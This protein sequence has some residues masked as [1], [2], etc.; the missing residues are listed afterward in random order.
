MSSSLNVYAL[1]MERLRQLIGSRDQTTIDAIV[2]GKEDFF[3]GVDDIHEEVE[4]T[5]ADAVAELLNG[6]W[7]EDAPGYLYGYALEAICSHIGETLPNICPISRASDWI[8]E[9]DALLEDKGIPV[10][11][12]GLVDGGS[13]VPIPEPD[14]Y[15]FIGTWTAAELALAKSAF[16]SADLTDI[17][18]EMALT[19]QQVRDWVQAAERNPGASLIG[20]LS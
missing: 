14:D 13:P 18:P 19:L 17:D 20:F 8:E 9:V 7:S 5:C 10:R 1:P 3:S 16:E 11:L 4:L 15:P 6:E 12:T 2:E